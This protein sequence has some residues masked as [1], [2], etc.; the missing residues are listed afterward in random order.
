M[1]RASTLALA[2]GLA[3]GGGATLLSRGAG[4]AD[5]A[6]AGGLRVAVVDVFACLNAAPRKSGIEQKRRDGR[7]A[8]ETYVQEQRNKIRDLAGE[9]ERLPQADPRRRQLQEE[10]ARAQSLLEFEAKW[11]ASQADAAYSED[12]ESLY[13]EV[14]AVIRD[15]A[16]AS[17]YSLVLF[18]SDDQLNL[19]RS[20][21]FVLS[22]AMRPVLYA[23]RGTDIT[24]M[25]KQKFAASKPPVPPSVPPPSP[26]APAPGAVPVPGPR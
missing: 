11:R 14:K 8:V 13:A 21:E 1:R 4:A 26:A 25:V 24:D 18:K 20:G 15:V 19:D 10:F 16:L 5:A 12:L 23:D 2:F 17:G 7:G 9:I 3:C 6:A 22:V